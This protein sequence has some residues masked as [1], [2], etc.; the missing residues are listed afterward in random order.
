MRKL[1]YILIIV[2]SFSSCNHSKKNTDNPI[3]EKL[4]IIDSLTAEFDSIRKNG[5]INV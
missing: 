5:Q 3:S 2:I 4:I 1:A